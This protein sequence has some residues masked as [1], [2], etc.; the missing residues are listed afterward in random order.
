ME[1]VVSRQEQEAAHASAVNAM[2]GMGLPY[3]NGLTSLHHLTHQQHQPHAWSASSAAAA[4]HAQMMANHLNGLMR[5]GSD[6][7]SMY[8]SSL[9]GHLSSQFL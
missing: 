2:K 3:P 1:G 7:M 4:S 9:Q 6:A 8:A 5:P